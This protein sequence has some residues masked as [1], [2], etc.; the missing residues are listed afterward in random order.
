[1]RKQQNYSKNIVPLLFCSVLVLQQMLS[2]SA[3]A[4]STITDGSGNPIAKDPIDS[5]AVGKDVFYLRPEAF[6]GK[7]GFRQFKDFN[8]AEGDVVNFLYR[9]LQLDTEGGTANHRYSDIDTFVNFIN[10]AN[11][12]TIHGIIN[13]MYELGETSMHSGNLVFISPNG[14]MVGSTGVLNV[15][16]LQIYTP[17]QTAFDAMRTGLPDHETNTTFSDG[18]TTA[19]AQNVTNTFDP[20][21]SALYTGSGA[22]TINGRVA[23]RGGI[24]LNG[25]QI[26]VGNGGLL[27]AGIGNDST[28]ITNTGGAD[29]LFGSLVN[30]DNMS[31]ANSFASANGK[32]VI[33]ANQ[34][35]DIGQNAKVRNYNVAAN[36]SVAIEN[37]GIR[38]CT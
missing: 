11:G 24:S 4:A 7:Y 31:S 29:I 25:G 8:I 10:N 12:A 21:N 3:F 1:M 2:N 9:A 14:V 26:N 15:G 37:T 28:Y 16:S 13:T 36:S 19:L 6:N 22:I 5:A 34:G 20:S 23:S 35:V 32:I 18:T 38:L 30:A 27:L 17:S 33:K